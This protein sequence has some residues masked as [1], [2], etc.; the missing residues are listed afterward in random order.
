MNQ[1]LLD[2]DQNKQT[3]STQKPEKKHTPN[4]MPAN[5]PDKFIDP[6]SGEIRLDAL[7]NSYLAMEKKLSKMIPAPAD[8]DS[9]SKVFQALGRPDHPENYDIDLSHGLFDR[10][11]ECDECMFEKGFNNDQAQL[12]YDL[13]AKKMVPLIVEMASEFQAD[14]EVEKLVET[15]GGPE[16]WR[17][18]SRQLLAFGQKNL[19]QDVLNG[20]S[21]SYE[22]VMALYRMMERDETSM[23]PRGETR[24]A[25]GEE[26]LQAMIRDPRYWKQKDP[27]FIRKVTQGFQKIYGQE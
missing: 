3:A 17:E 12:V 25:E 6:E 8:E 19:P 5:L 24:T 20:L 26:D 22:G 14:R 23:N 27:A 10:D 21:S 15:F 9:K 11:M 18:V 4:G 13:A 7:I 1:T 16:K 2:T